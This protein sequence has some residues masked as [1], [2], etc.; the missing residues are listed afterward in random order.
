MAWRLRGRM[1]S[2]QGLNL[3]YVAEGQGPFVLL[4]HGYPTSSFDWHAVWPQLQAGHRLVAL[5]FPGLG[6][7]SKPLALEYSLTLHAQAVEALLHHL[8]RP[9]VHIV[10][11]DL[12]VRVAQTLLVNRASDET[13]API[14]SLA[15][16]N[17][18]MCPE[19]YRPRLVQRLLA[20]PMGGWLAPRI[21][22]RA[23]DRTIT[24][25]FGRSSP[26]APELLDDFWSLVE[27]GDGRLI[28]HAVSRFWRVTPTQR[29]LLVNALLRS[30]AKLRLINGSADPNSGEAMV[31]RWLELA[32][33]T[34]VVRMPDTGHWPQLEA[35]LKTAAAIRELWRRSAMERQPIDAKAARISRA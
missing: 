21:P 13:L 33:S 32:P 22:R 5:D 6:F 9:P 25:L 35:P 4:L 10:A 29:N 20:S 24:G 26:P 17:G 15:L 16:L 12:G 2:W 34:D 30:T 8:G 27:E 14:R 11:H 3:F 18:A 7:S 23:F 19:A 28:T 31:R 1:M